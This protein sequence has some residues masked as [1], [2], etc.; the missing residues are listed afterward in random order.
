[1]RKRSERMKTSRKLACIGLAIVFATATGDRLAPLGAQPLDRISAAPSAGTNLPE[2]P[3]F[4]W[5][6]PPLSET[7]FERFSEM[8]HAGFNLVLPAIDDTGGLA[9]SRLQLE[10]AAANGMKCLVW[11]N[12]FTELDIQVPTVIAAMDSIL[13]DYR[14]HPAVAGY[15]L[16]DEPPRTLFNTLAAV[17]DL[18][19]RLD[20][21]NPGWNNLLGR[22]SFRT[23][24]ALESY[25][26]DYAASV[27]PVVLCNDHYEFT[28]AGDRG[29]FMEN[30]AALNRLSRELGVPF[31][32]IVLLVEHGELRGLTEGELK[33]QVSHLLAYGAQGIGYFTYWTPMPDPRWNWQPA[34]IDDD[35]RRTTWYDVLAGFNPRVSAAGTELKRLTW[36]L[37]EHA[38]NVPAGAQAFVPDDWV[39]AVEGR[40][41][42][43]QFVDGN[44]GRFLLVAN[45]DSAGAQTVKLT[46]P[47]TRTVRALGDR[48]GDWRL[49]PVT[50]SH[51]G[52]RTQAVVEVALAAGDFALLELSGEVA[53][54]VIGG[55]TPGLIVAPN[56]ARGAVTFSVAAALHGATLEIL[57]ANGRRVWRRALSGGGANVRWDGRFDS[58]ERAPEGVYFTRLE[59]RRGATVRRMVWLGR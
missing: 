9:D 24:A 7:T 11:D 28:T 45:S 6:S 16:G 36:L 20:P 53:A 22:Q 32:S 56:P 49:L 2:F 54:A 51:D 37:T 19:R 27:E 55:S 39:S 17:H 3:I 8:A 34:V 50:E 4:G 42:I 38:G 52:R 57:D 12:R 35:G 5:V 13:A 25:T 41:A 18:I 47:D 44:D 26:R 59:D 46:L 21:K 58:G 15:Y 1:M 33:W 43:G 48:V 14:D 40:A 29:Q 31:W 30:A 10:A 23:V